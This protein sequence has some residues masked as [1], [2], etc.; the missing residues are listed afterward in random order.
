M[1]KELG[2]KKSFSQFYIS[3]KLQKCP[4]NGRNFTKID[5][6]GVAAHKKFFWVYF[7]CQTTSIIFL[8]SN[9]KR[10]RWKKVLFTVL[11]ILKVT[12]LPK[13]GP[14]M[15]KIDDFGSAAHKKNF[16]GNFWGQKSKK[17]FQH[18]LDITL[19]FTLGQFLGQFSHFPQTI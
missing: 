2:G 7:L 17:C 10:I 15:A 12:K 11:L 18:F 9:A 6:F 3:S 4:K 5:I 14:K 1:Q 8:W 13:N 19:K 16:L